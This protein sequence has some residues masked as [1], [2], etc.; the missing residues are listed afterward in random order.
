MKGMEALAAD[1]RGQRRCERPAAARG[2]QHGWAHRR[3]VA[4]GGTLGEIDAGKEG[5]GL[6]ERVRAGTGPGP[7]QQTGQGWEA[8]G[9][10]GCM[11]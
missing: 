11:G 2:L 10:G 8:E 4:E 5:P 7:G 9:L 1:G 6:Q 3:L